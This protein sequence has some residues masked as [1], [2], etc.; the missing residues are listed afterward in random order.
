MMSAR[1]VRP[2]LAFDPRMQ[3]R[4]KSI[5][6][7][8]SAATTKSESYNTPPRACTRCCLVAPVQLREGVA[9]FGV[10]VDD[11]GHRQYRC[12]PCA[13]VDPRMHAHADWLRAP[14]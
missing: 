12:R 3:D 10:P 7:P 1:H 9:S 14:Q 13:A 6:P 8:K 4:I 5:P 11:P 2:T